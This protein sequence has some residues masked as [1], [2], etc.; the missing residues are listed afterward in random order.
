MAEPNAM[1]AHFIRNS[2]GVIGVPR[3]N[4]DLVGACVVRDHQG[5]VFADCEVAADFAEKL[6]ADLED[7]RPELREETCVVMTDER[8]NEIMYCVAVGGA[9]RTSSA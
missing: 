3:F 2:E 4:F 5:L 9:R 7:I 8:R 1:A 6:A